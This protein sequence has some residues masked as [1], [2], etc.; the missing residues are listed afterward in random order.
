MEVLSS[1]AGYVPLSFN[2]YYNK[3]LMILMMKL[4]TIMGWP[5]MNILII[6]S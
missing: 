1:S 2:M 4:V 6:I 3:T 5:H